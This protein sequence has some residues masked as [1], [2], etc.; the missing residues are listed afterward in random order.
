MSCNLPPELCGLPQPLSVP[1]SNNYLSFYNHVPVSSS[2][3]QYQPLVSTVYMATGCS[4][5]NV[6]PLVTRD[7]TVCGDVEVSCDM[8]VEGD[9]F[10]GTLESG[11]LSLCNLQCDSTM[12]LSASLAIDI[13][14]TLQV[15]TLASAGPMHL[16]SPNTIYIDSSTVV[17]TGTLQTGTLSAV[18]GV[19]NIPT[20]I[21]TCT[22]SC[23]TTLYMEATTVYMAG[24]LQVQTLNTCTVTC[25]TTLLL[26]A[27]VVQV[28]QVMTIGGTLNTCTVACDTTL[29]LPDQVHI[30]GSLTTGTLIACTID[31]TVPPN[32]VVI[33]SILATD[34]LVV[35]NVLSVC[36]IVCPTQPLNIVAN[37]VQTAGTLYAAQGLESCTFPIYAST[38]QACNTTVTISGNLAVSG[39]IPVNGTNVGTGPGQIF[40]GV[41][42]NTLNFRTLTS[43]DNTISITTVGNNVNFFTNPGLLRGPS[44]LQLLFD[45]QTVAP[46]T[47]TT[48]T[49]TVGTN[50]GTAF[51]FTPPS[52]FTGGITLSS[53]S[54]IF[55]NWQNT[56][57]GT[58]VMVR[59]NNISTSV[60]AWD[61]VV[62]MVAGAPF[63]QGVQSNHFDPFIGST[64]SQIQVYHNAPVSLIFNQ[65][66]FAF[67]DLVGGFPVLFPTPQLYMVPSFV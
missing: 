27:P 39:T 54:G 36:S 33:N 35:N 5:P 24:N 30:A 57:G 42:G 2:R 23:P 26:Q 56:L 64:P 29:Y 63:L 19:L 8:R 43:P 40:A 67:G 14:S 22:I 58:F 11:T 1:C 60:L 48:L 59:I 12:F 37:T 44:Y 25:P 15:T 55:M 62:P 7:L 32:M 51:T 18:G 28:P 61:W 65:T 47:W 66:G 34:T 4:N 6:R 52:T 13:L 16:V 38:I 21:D 41:T 3:V 45:Q 50:T 20:T 9:L 53:V 17:V 49:M 10:A 31:C 46:N